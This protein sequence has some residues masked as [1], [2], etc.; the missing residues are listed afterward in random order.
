MLFVLGALLKIVEIGSTFQ[1]GNE[2]NL[3]CKGTMGRDIFGICWNRIPVTWFHAT[4]PGSMEDWREM[5]FFVIIITSL[6]A[7]TPIFSLLSNLAQKM[8]ITLTRSIFFHFARNVLCLKP[9]YLTR[10]SVLC[11]VPSHTATGLNCK[12]E[13][14]ALKIWTLFTGWYTLS[15][16]IHEVMHEL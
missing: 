10:T 16:H 13:S 8:Q 5:H 7:V 3:V 15:L 2:G 11:P 12:C 6:T 1:S 14:F 9:D 4:F